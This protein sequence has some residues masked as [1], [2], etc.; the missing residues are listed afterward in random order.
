VV[1]RHSG[2]PLQ[3]F[4]RTEFAAAG[5][6]TMI[7]HSLGAV[8]SERA[9]GHG[10]ARVVVVASA[11]SDGTEDI[12][13]R[14]AAR[15]PR[16]TLLVE[17]VRSGKA[18]AINWF[19]CE[20]TEPVCLLIGG[21]TLPAPGA[22]AELVAP[23]ADPAVGMTGARVVPSN[24]RKGVGRLVHW[25]WEM[26]HEVALRHPKLGEA[27]AVQR[28]FERLDTGLLAD[29]VNIEHLI[30]GAGLELRYAGRAVVFNRG[31]GTLRDYLAH[32]RRNHGL[33]L[34]VAVATGYHAATMSGANIGPAALRNLL[35][36]PHRLPV[37]T[38]AIVLEVAAR[39]QAR[40]YFRQ[41]MEAG[42]WRPIA[43]AKRAFQVDFETLGDERK[44]RE[45][46]A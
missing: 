19:L 35:R 22:L 11:C 38:A 31:A 15:D 24:E 10:V 4:R 14:L 5:D 45:E 25:L 41:G 32:R 46:V 13:R 2:A 44:G 23:L 8:L 20:T 29:E 37:A 40:Y 34:K 26:H 21:D 6:T 16:V 1:D 9:G 42:I 17:P 18:S 43:S 12:V 30:T 27:V 7:E 3:S 28:V 33:H 36:N 39:A